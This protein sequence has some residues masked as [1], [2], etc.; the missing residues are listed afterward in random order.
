VSKLEIANNN[1]QD[2]IKIIIDM[3]KVDEKS[4]S[5]RYG[6]VEVETHYKKLAEVMNKKYVVS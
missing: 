5:C 1:I 6:E 3:K 4:F 2:L